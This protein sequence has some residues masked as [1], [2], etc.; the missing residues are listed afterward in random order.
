[1]KLGELIYLFKDLR[2]AN[3]AKLPASK[4]PFIRQAYARVLDKLRVIG[5]LYQPVSKKAI[6][7]MD[8]TQSM[9]DKLIKLFQRKIN[10]RDKTK[11][12]KSVLKEQLS[13]IAGIGSAKADELIKLKLTHIS[14]LSQKKWQMHLSKPTIVWLKHRPMIKIPHAAIK[15]LKPKLTAFAGAQI[16][17]SFRRKKPFSRDIDIMIVSN[18]KNILKLYATSLKS[19]FDVHIISSGSN[20][21]SLLI[22]Q[23]RR[24]DNYIKVDV[25]H[26]KPRH[27]YAMLLY[28]TGSKQFNIRMRAIARRQNYLLNQKALFK[29]P[30]MTPVNITSE[31]QIFNLLK[32]AYVKPEHR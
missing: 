28:S 13:N 21:I 24:H 7:S 30:G 16:V 5:D 23:G 1:M 17:G 14:Q 2:D 8:L 19:D 12:S 10:D 18:K 4:L 22:S 25:F 9:K 3:L 15:A 31:K 26:T 32:M 20:K 29:L 27:Q 11:I 6:E